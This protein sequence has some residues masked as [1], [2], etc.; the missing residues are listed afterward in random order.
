MAQLGEALRNSIND[1]GIKVN[2]NLAAVTF[3]DGAI[4]ADPADVVTGQLLN[5]FTVNDGGTG[6]TW[7]ASVAGVISRAA[8]ETVSGTC[9]TGG[10]PTFFRI[11]IVSEAAETA[12]AV[13]HRIQGTCGQSGTDA[14]LDSTFFPM[15]LSTVYPLGNLPIT[16]PVG[17]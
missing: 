3:F 5:K 8:A 2:M 12:S 9:T 14:I 17:S 10:S 15:V 7:D 13:F 11:H 4:P 16:L 1:L 6:F